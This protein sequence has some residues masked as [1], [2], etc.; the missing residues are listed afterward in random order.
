MNNYRARRDEQFSCAIQWQ[1]MN[2]EI[3]SKL[4]EWHKVLREILAGVESEQ[5]NSGSTRAVRDQ[6]M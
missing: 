4:P 6:A 2:P 1:S 3:E 5:N